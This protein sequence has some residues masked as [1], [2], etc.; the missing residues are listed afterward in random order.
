MKEK[1][2]RALGCHLVGATALILTKVI[3]D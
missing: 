3:K 2:S 1:N